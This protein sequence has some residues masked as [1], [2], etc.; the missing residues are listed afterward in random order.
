M[1]HKRRSVASYIVYLRWILNISMPASILVARLLA[2]ARN[3]RHA[4]TRRSMAGFSVVV[5]KAVLLRRTLN[6][7]YARLVEVGSNAIA[8]NHGMGDSVLITYVILAL[9]LGTLSVVVAQLVDYFGDSSRWRSI[10]SAA[11]H[12]APWPSIAVLIA[13]IPTIW[14]VARWCVF[15]VLPILVHGQGSVSFLLKYSIRLASALPTVIIGN[16]IVI[17]MHLAGVEP[18]NATAVIALLIVALVLMVLPTVLQVSGEVAKSY[19]GEELPHALA[20]GLPA[21][22]AARHVVLPRIVTTLHTAIALA[23]TRVI[24]EI[25]VVVNTVPLARIRADALPQDP[26]DLFEIFQTLYSSVTVLSLI[27]I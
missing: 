25:A 12:D 22:F 9:L 19:H 14:L 26:K 8:R 1:N 13:L 23:I 18:A 24:V 17:S 3:R 16:A 5:R 2:A 15:R 4:F 7:S 10:G 11:L 27:H 6:S 21:P 20:L